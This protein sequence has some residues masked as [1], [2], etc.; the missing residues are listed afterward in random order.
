[1]P[2]NQGGSCD[3]KDG[4]DMN[5]KKVVPPSHLE[6]GGVNVINA[7]R[8]RIHR[9]VVECPAVQGILRDYSVIALIAIVHRRQQ[10]GRTQ[11]DD[12]RDDGHVDPAALTS[13]H[14]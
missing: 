11:D 14:K 1:P 13:R 3:E 12:E 9:G 4:K 8:L 7:W 6:N 2:Y 5:G 10:R